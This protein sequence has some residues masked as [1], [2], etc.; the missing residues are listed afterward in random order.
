MRVDVLKDWLLR[1]WPIVRAALLVG[2][3]VLQPVRASG[4]RSE[5]SPSHDSGASG[6]R[7]AD[8]MSVPDAAKAARILENQWPYYGGKR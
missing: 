7:T 5:R 6:S 4:F 8:E 1:N 2:N 3:D